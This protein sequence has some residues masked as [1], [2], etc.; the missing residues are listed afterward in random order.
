MSL[1]Y[2][3]NCVWHFHD[4]FGLGQGPEH[5]PAIRNG[6]L[7]IDLIMEEAEEF[8]T[9]VHR[10]DVVAAAD[11][12]ADLLYVT[13]GSAVEFGI[14]LEPVFKEVH[15]SNLRKTGGTLRA[16]GKLLKGPNWVPPDIKGCLERQR[17]RK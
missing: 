15:A 2:V 6:Q 5:D 12:L 4:K 13:L 10:G 17:K 14:D 7:R 3:Q 11:A 16:D 9:A 1:R 8:E